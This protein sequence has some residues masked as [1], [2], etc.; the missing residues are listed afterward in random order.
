MNK[1]IIISEAG[2]VKIVEQKMPIPAK[3]E[4]LLKIL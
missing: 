2:K 1:S 4:A 3:G